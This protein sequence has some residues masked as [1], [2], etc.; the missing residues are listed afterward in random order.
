MKVLVFPQPHQHLV[1]FGIFVNLIDEK[2]YLSLAV[3]STF[4]LWKVVNI[5]IYK[6]Y[7]H[8]FFCELSVHISFVNWPFISLLSEDFYFL[9][10]YIEI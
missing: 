1:Y 6:S 9:T 7:L 10:F 4:L 5:F 2:Q 3:I 8:F